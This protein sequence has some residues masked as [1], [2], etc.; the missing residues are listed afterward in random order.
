MLVGRRTVCMCDK[1]VYSRQQF[2]CDML[3]CSRQQFVCVTCWSAGD[4]NLCV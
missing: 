3:V 1:L 2:V 4:R